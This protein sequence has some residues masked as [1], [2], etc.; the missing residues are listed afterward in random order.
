VLPDN[1][2]FRLR[3]FVPYFEHGLKK[4][5]GLK[6]RVFVVFPL[7]GLVGDVTFSLCWLRDNF[8][9]L[10]RSHYEKPR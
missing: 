4:R 8:G 7:Q 1:A 6:G 9:L 5:L 10:H 3:S 2:F